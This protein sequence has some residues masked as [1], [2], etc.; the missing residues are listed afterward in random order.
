MTKKVE[1]KLDERR[2]GLLIR[3]SFHHTCVCRKSTQEPLMR[4]GLTK[5]NGRSYEITPKG[6]KFV[7]DYLKAN[8]KGRLQ[9]W[10]AISIG[11]AVMILKDSGEAGMT[12][13]VEAW[14]LIY[15]NGEFCPTPRTRVGGTA[16]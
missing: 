7:A 14:A 9:T 13:K 5:S 4:R 12:K 6:R 3:M 11:N 2:L 1:R 8:P 15:P 16:S 10:E